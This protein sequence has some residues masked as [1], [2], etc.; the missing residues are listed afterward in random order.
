MTDSM[1][2]AAMIGLRSRQR[3]AVGGSHGESLMSTAIDKLICFLFGHMD[4]GVYK[5][6]GCPRCGYPSV[7]FCRLCGSHYQWR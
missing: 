6:H 7:A 5:E 2:V 1:A 4:P 3:G